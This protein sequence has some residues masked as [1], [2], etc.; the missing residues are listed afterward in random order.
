[1]ADNK[2]IKDGLGNIFTIRMRDVSALQD[3]SVQRAMILA[4]P[5]PIDYGAGGVYTHC[6]KSGVMAPSMPANS[7]IYSFRWASPGMIALIWRVK[8]EAW[9]VTAFSG[10]LVSFDLSIARNFTSGDSGGLSAI[11]N[12]NNNKLRTAMAASSA[13]IEWSNTG[14]LTPG[15]RTLDLAP[16]G[17][18]TQ[19][20][21]VANSTLFTNDPFVLFEK[22]S[23]S[24][25]LQ[26]ITNEGFVINATVP[27]SSST[28]QFDVTID[29]N[30]VQTF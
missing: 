28:W 6:A 29:W 24:H 17:S 8:V 26:L 12:G 27:S 13:A 16:I 25:P 18:R 15:T 1:M 11:L 2:Q 23:G 9:T 20:A 21:P 14:A 30:E 19:P 4:T 10:G 3:G 7:P 22:L 5:Y